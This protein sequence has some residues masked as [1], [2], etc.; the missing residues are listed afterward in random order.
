MVQKEMVKH[1]LSMNVHAHLYGIYVNPQSQEVY[2]H[3]RSSWSVH[4]NNSTFCFLN[5]KRLIQW[6]LSSDH[7]T[8]A[9]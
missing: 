2:L 4:C 5:H 1:V 7:I 3:V 6:N 9:H 8:E